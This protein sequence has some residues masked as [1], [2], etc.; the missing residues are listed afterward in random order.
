MQLPTTKTT[1]TVSLSNFTTLV[2]GMPKI[3]K[4]TFAAGFPDALFLDCEGG[5]Q[6]LETYRVPIFT[7]NEFKATC[8]EIQKGDHQFKTIVIDT[9]DQA[10]QRCREHVLGA[11]GVM[12]ESDAEI[13][14]GWD[15]V[16]N[17]FLRVL[18]RLALL[19][20]GLVLISHA[21]EKEFKTPTGKVTRRIPT[22]PGKVGLKVVGMAD[23][24]LYADHEITTAQKGVTSEKRVLRTKPTSIYEAGDRTGL[25]PE[26]IPMEFSA[27][28]EAFSAAARQMTPEQR[29]GAEAAA[30]QSA[31]TAAVLSG[32]DREETSAKTAPAATSTEPET[33]AVA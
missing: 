7:W 27:F 23:L 21:V 20:Y 25:L 30:L 17:E 4:S 13:G 28:A 15:L 12:H 19:P 31:Q 14:K 3:G 6:S 11:L 10:Y 1:P 32:D 18:A 2:Y 8:T 9:V 24:Y 5:L 16:T 29:K 33:K 22:L 26:S